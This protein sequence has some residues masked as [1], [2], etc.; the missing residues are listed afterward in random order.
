MSCGC[1]KR[2]EWMNERWPGSG[3]AVAKVANPIKQH[4]IVI[5]GLSMIAY[6]LWRAR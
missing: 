2:Q 5:I 4:A 3:D 1:E 6:A